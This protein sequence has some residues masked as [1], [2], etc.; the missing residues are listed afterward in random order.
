MVSVV[1]GC[2]LQ[3]NVTKKLTIFFCRLFCTKYTNWH[4]T[5]QEAQD[6]NKQNQLSSV[7]PFSI[8]SFII[9]TL[10]SFLHKKKE[11]ENKQ[12]IT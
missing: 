10:S 9:F 5:T 2:P 4:E 3:V 8:S 7:F 1:Y 11:L 12:D 6:K